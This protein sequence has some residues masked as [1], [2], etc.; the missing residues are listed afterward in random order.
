[1]SLKGTEFVLRP[2][3]RIRL[4]RKQDVIIWYDGCKQTVRQTKR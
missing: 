1:M 4:E 2:W 3:Q